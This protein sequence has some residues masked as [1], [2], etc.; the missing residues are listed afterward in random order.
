MKIQPV[1]GTRDFYPEEMAFRTWLFGKMRKAAE[2]FGYQEYEGPILEPIELYTA[3]TSEEIVNEQTFRITDRSGKTLVLRPEMTPSVSRMVAARAPSLVKPIR[4]YSIGPRWRYEQPQK[5]RTREFYQWDVDCFGPHTPLADAEI[6]SV[7]CTFLQAVG[8][9][10]KDARI[11]INDRRLMEEKLKEGVGLTSSQI[12]DALNLIDRMK[13]IDANEL[14]QYGE[15]R[16]FTDRQVAAIQTLITDTDYRYESEWL[17]EVFATVADFGFG[18]YIEY[19]PS[20]VRGLLYYSGVVFE[21]CDTE[22][23]FRSILGGGRYDSL[24]ESLGGQALSAVGFAAGDL[25]IGEVLTYYKI[26]P[27]LNSTT[28][29]VLV[30]VFSEALTRTALAT[31]R[32]IRDS[33]VNTEL[34]LTPSTITDQLSYA[35]KKKIPYVVLVGPDEESRNEVLLKDMRS[36]EQSKVPRIKLAERL[37]KLLY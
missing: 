7:A 16:G 6:I 2:S 13:K 26:V 12:V 1:K 10:G 25:V 14:V 18:N 5:G 22:Q 24:V 27:Q 28:S 21:A 36:G 23:K 35:N 15:A 32:M 4:W 19:D 30:T 31:A 20:V 37:K 11:K 29:H 9:T 3:K 17:T 33:G 34:F 8:L